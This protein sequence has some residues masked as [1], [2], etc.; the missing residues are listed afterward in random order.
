MGNFSVFRF[1]ELYV[2]KNMDGVLYV[3]EGWIK[4]DD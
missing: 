1:D 4:N 3:I 2:R